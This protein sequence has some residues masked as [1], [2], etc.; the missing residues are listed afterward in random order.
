MGSAQSSRG[1]CSR[2]GRGVRRTRQVGWEQACELRG[3]VAIGCGR[4]WPLQADLLLQQDR[5]RRRLRDVGYEIRPHPALGSRDDVGV[6]L[7]SVKAL[8]ARRAPLGLAAVDR[9]HPRAWKLRLRSSR[10]EVVVHAV[11]ALDE[12]GT[13]VANEA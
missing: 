1:R 2:E 7:A 10:L 8:G 9:Y 4:G 13:I 5:G 11:D 12:A 3:V 6:G